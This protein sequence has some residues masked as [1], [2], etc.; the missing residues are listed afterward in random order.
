MPKFKDETDRLLFEGIKSLS[1]E[2]FVRLKGEIEQARASYPNMFSS[3]LVTSSV[4]GKQ[5]RKSGK[6]TEDEEIRSDNSHLV[7]RGLNK[8][9]RIALLLKAHPSYS[10]EAISSLVDGNYE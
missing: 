1:P 5:R 8:E 2:S 10:Y 4:N 7:V 6:P 9:E 3:S